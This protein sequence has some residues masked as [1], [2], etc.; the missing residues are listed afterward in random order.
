M[1]CKNNFTLIGKPFA[2]CQD[3]TLWS[4]L[5]KCEKIVQQKKPCIKI[6]LQNGLSYKKDCSSKLPGESCKLECEKG[7]KIIGNDKIILSKFLHNGQL[8]RNVRAQH[9]LYQKVYLLRMIA[10]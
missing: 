2:I 6:K 8:C 9:R 10:V 5:P 7:G 3:S 1:K 4:D